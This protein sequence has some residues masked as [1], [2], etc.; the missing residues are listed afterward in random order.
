[1]PAT[2]HFPIRMRYMRPEISSSAASSA[3]IALLIALNYDGNRTFFP[4]TPIPGFAYANRF[5]DYLTYVVGVPYSSITFEPVKGFQL[6]AGYTLIDTLEA[7]LAYQFTKHWAIFGQ[8]TDQLSPFHIDNTNPDR[9]LF[10]HTHEL[11]AGMRWNPTQLIR[12]S[13]SAGW[14]FGQEFS[15]GFD[16]RS[17]NPVRHITNAPLRGAT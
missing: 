4:D 7:K 2:A 11:E 13:V 8:Y 9:R 3:K 1:M 17:L 5:N 16:T 6:E 14:A 12:F 10:F 15:T